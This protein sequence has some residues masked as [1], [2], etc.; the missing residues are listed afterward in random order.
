MHG[1]LRFVVGG[2]ACANWRPE[3]VKIEVRRVVLLDEN[4]F[5]PLCKTGIVPRRQ[6]LNVDH[7]EEFEA[8]R[9]REATGRAH[10]KTT[11]DDHRTYQQAN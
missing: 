1:A 4:G 8:V 3:A 2:F 5:P 11:A 9:R 10:K 7:V 6:R